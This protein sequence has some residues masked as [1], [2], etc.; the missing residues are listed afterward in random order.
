MIQ[1]PSETSTPE[2]T[3]TAIICNY[4]HGAYVERALHA[5]LDQSR[6]PDE[7]IVLDDAS[8]DNSVEL[9]SPIAAGDPIVRFVR[10]DVN[11]GV[12]C[13]MSRAVSLAKSE[14][15]YCGAADDYTLPG[16]L[17]GCEKQIL[18]HPRTGICSSDLLL[19]D[20]LTGVTTAREGSWDV[21]AG[22]YPPD[23]MVK[24]LRHLTIPGSTTLFRKDAY[25][26]AGGFYP[27]TRW[28][29]DFFVLQ[30][31]ALREGGCYFPGPGTSVTVLPNSYYGAGHK[32]RKAHRDTIRFMLDK[33]E[34]PE[35]ADIKEKWRQA[36]LFAQFGPIVVSAVIAD[37]RR[38][39]SWRLRNA[40]SSITIVFSKPRLLI[41]PL[42]RAL[43]P[44][45]PAPLLWVYRK[46]KAAMSR[47][48]H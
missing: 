14:W 16:F 37:Y 39:D 22:Y 30:I 18:A 7:L 31:I 32:D 33:M 42:K 47:G 13:S 23:K 2:I 41:D 24:I 36:Q 35:F 6:R 12:N 44:R 4:N 25:E 3:I 43:F 15:I 20:G 45:T 38:L 5:L 27:E 46:L 40:I 48:R 10:N 28:H 8:T 9:I 19:V 17:E 21:P 26:Q 1:P 34:S 29:S 11:K